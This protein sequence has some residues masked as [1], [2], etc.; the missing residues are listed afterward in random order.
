MKINQLK[1]GSLLSYTQMVLSVL[2]SLIYTP[3]VLNIL[4][5]SEYGLYQTAS[6]AT[7]LLTMLN[8]GL[9]I[10]YVHFYLKYHHK[11]DEEGAARFNGLY[12][13]ILCTLGLVCLILG[14]LMTWKIEWFFADGLS[15]S[16]YQIARILM[17]L[18]IINIT[19]SFPIST[20]TGILSA[21]EEFVFLGIINI[22]KNLAVHGFSIL[23]LF[24]GYHSIGMVC[25]K[26]AVGVLVDIAYIFYAFF[27]LKCKI[28]FGN[29]EKGLF[30]SLL[31]YTSFIAV[32]VLIDQINLNIDKMLLARFRGPEAVAVYNI[33]FLIY[34]YYQTMS[35]SISN[36]LSPRVH[37]YVY[38]TEGDPTL[39]KQLLT[40]LFIK[41]GRIQFFILGL[42]STGF[43]FFGKAFITCYWANAEYENAYY[44]ALILVFSA[45][46][47]LMQNVGIAIL[48]ALNKHKFRS[49][50][51]LMI[52][53][54]NFALSIKLCQLYGEIGSALGTALAFLIGNVVIINIYYHKKANVD[55]IRFW[56]AILR[57]S[58]GLIIP[59]TAGILLAFRIDQSNIFVFLAGILVYCILYG[60]SVWV[61]AMSPAE[62]QILI[63]PLKRIIKRG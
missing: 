40:D 57:A 38:D 31:I 17:V 4:G 5:K 55:M 20:F 11:K 41:V 36:V 10:S 14:L 26:V 9:N 29:F 25:V 60:G 47:P 1:G 30:K 18:M 56:K 15:A 49:I 58:I 53:L 37:K 39:R 52:A 3:I 44:V 59:V 61:F 24:L 35:T 13:T 2:V 23:S 62:K 45:T 51:Y 12:M 21:N 34:T 54:V 43:L 8:L 63:G 50:L 33:G 27:K 7:A 22:V 19:L 48:Q 28:K 6:S 42:I 46:V 32:N 16:E